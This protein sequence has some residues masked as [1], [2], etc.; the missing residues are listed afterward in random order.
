MGLDAKSLISPKKFTRDDSG[1]ITPG[2]GG[3]GEHIVVYRAAKEIETLKVL[4][5]L[6]E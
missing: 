6:K 2:K 5:S 4:G 3:N 1:Q